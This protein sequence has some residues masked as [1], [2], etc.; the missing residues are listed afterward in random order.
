[1]SVNRDCGDMEIGVA[2]RVGTKF[3]LAAVS[4]DDKLARIA[5]DEKVAEIVPQLE[6]TITD[7][8][9]D[10]IGYDQ[11]TVAAK[12]KARDEKNAADRKAEVEGRAAKQAKR[13]GLPAPPEGETGEPI[14]PGESA[15]DGETEEDNPAEG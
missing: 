7:Q 1:M 12:V 14:K 8:I 11:E 9:L 2:I 10:H 5:M 4:D 6:K 3:T 15:F 13:A